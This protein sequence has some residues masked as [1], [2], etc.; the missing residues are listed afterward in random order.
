MSVNWT[1]GHA[2]NQQRFT[3]PDGGRRTQ[4]QADTEVRPE[5]EERVFAWEREGGGRERAY[6]RMEVTGGPRRITDI[7]EK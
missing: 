5:D 7:G 3:V 6:Y 2:G 4:H 1:G